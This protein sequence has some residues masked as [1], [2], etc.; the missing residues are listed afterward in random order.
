[1]LS[2]S[3]WNPRIAA[4][5]FIF[6]RPTR[7]LS[8]LSPQL[9]LIIDRLA[10]ASCHV[11]SGGEIGEFDQ[12]SESRVHTMRWAI[13][14]LIFTL[15]GCSTNPVP[16]QASGNKLPIAASTALRKAS[17]FE[18]FSLEPSEGEKVPD[19][20]NFH[21]WTILGSTAI[22]DVNIRDRVL[23][24][25]EAGVAENDGRAA[26]CFDPRHGI[27]VK[28][29][30]EQHDFVICFRCYSGHW[31][32]NGKRNE[33]FWPTNSPQP[34]FDRVLK[35]ASVPLATPAQK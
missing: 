8:R 9:P 7:V 5:R 31:Y 21:G 29:K 22:T 3:C 24:A 14:L 34:T 13:L 6:L 15:T 27:R 26:G 18:L 16:N 2:I 33:T 19:S 4:K 1:L 20:S 23:D 10:H 32:T 35:N 11:T 30:G 17:T 28:Y 12:Y 25:L